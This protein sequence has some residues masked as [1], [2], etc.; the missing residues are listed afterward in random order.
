EARRG[1][2]LPATSIAW[3]PW[4]DDGMAYA[5]A[6]RWERH[7]LPAMAPDLAI[8]ELESV[9][10]DPM[11]AS[12]VVADVDWDTLAQARATTHTSH[13]LKEL[14]RSAAGDTAAD[15]S[16]PG[17]GTLRQRLA[18]LGAAEQERA[19]VEFVRSHVAAVLGHRRADT[20]DVD[21]AFKELGFDSLAAVT[22]RNRLN[23]AAELKL[24]P[25]LLFDH[26]TV[27]ALARVLREEALGL[28]GDGGP[29]PVVATATDDEPIAIVGMSCRFPGGVRTP[30][31]LW[32]LLVDGR[33]VLTDFP[34]G[35]GWD[36]DSLFDSD[37]DETGKSYVDKGAFLD[38]A[39]AFDPKFFGISPREA[40]T[41]DPQQR[42]LLK[43]SW[44]AFERA[45]IDGTLLH[46]SQ[47]GVFIGSNGQDYA[48]NL[49]E[50]PAE[51]VEGHLVTGSAASVVSGR[52]SYTFGLEG[53]AVTVDT[54]CS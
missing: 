28:S 15:R 53:P 22:L 37:P 26:P 40:T 46:G 3:G 34:D 38:D 8:A 39:G 18:G 50:A 54:A 6:D 25:T 52:I 13:L 4:A 42:L 5:V 36:L 27:R 30:E 9:V 23:A 35:R 10:N 45:G 24:S 29:V 32:N 14:T 21:R 43:T 1:E 44:E 12:L 48:R 7:G 16:A 19:V 2:G 11:A 17:G 41:M 47:T 20:V 51:N 33:D 31:D 49:R